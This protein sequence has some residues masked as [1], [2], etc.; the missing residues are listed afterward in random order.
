MLSN[1]FTQAAHPPHLVGIEKGKNIRDFEKFFF[2]VETAYP[3]L[4]W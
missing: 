3:P 2:F 4:K 1:I